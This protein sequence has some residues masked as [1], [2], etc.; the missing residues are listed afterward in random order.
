MFARAFNANN[1]Q[2]TMLM[3]A[4]WSQVKITLLV[5][6]MGCSYPCVHYDQVKIATGSPILKNGRGGVLGVNRRKMTIDA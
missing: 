6:I 4:G 1:E 2:R 5:R 3:K